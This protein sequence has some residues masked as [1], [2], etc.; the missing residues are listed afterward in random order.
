MQSVDGI[1]EFLG[2]LVRKP[3]AE[4]SRYAPH[5]FRLLYV[6]TS[7]HRILLAPD[8]PSPVLEAWRTLDATQ[9]SD[10]ES[11]ANY[12]LGMRAPDGSSRLE[13]MRAS[14]GSAGRNRKSSRGVVPGRSFDAAKKELTETEKST[15]DGFIKNIVQQVSSRPESVRALSDAIDTAGR[16]VSGFGDELPPPNRSSIPAGRFISG[17]LAFP[18]CGRVL[19]RPERRPRN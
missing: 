4:I 1:H 8:G 11:R 14:A 2:Q 16:P 19:A 3:R 15:V 7:S 13:A 12:K 17:P 10:Q 6:G 5:L 18:A 9:R